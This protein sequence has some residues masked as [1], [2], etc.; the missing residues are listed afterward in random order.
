MFIENEGQAFAPLVTNN[1]TEVVYKNPF[2]FSLT[3]IE[4]GGAF[5]MSVSFRSLANRTI[6]TICSLVN[7]RVLLLVFLRFPKRGLSARRLRL[8]R[9]PTS[10][11]TS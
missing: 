6:L 1:R 2:G 5:T 4:A 8:D 7:T 9:T 10:S 11:S 3:S